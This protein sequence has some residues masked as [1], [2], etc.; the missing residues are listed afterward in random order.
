MGAKFGKVAIVGMGLMGG[1]LGRALLKSKAAKEVTGIGRNE[2][3]LAFALKSGAATEVTTDYEAGFLDADIIVFGVPV[4]DIPGLFR[5][6]YGFMGSRSV[7]TD[8]GSVKETIVSE[9]EKIEK[10][11]GI[12]RNIFVGSHPMVG[13]EK[14]GIANSSAGLYEGGTC[15]VTPTSRTDKKKEAYVRSFWESVGMKAVTMTPAAHDEKIS[16]ISHL[17]HLLAFL[18]SNMEAPAIRKN[19]VIIGRGFKDMTR[20]G[21]SNEKI[22]SGIFLENKKAITG[23][24]DRTI[25]ELEKIRKII[26]ASDEN[27]LKKYIRNARK[28]RE[29][30]NK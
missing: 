28:L 1:S 22:W 13:S 6:N 19:S 16:G 25:A 11:S 29:S 12:D 23:D 7:V 20:I 10:G 21:A 15:I 14:T 5:K 27:K 9:I 30:L 8:M 18:L 4:R 3:K 2:K 26:R 24:I 17:P